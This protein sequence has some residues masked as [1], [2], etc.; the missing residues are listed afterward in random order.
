MEKT[1]GN[2]ADE[3]LVSLCEKHGVA[4]AVVRELLQIEKEYQT[5]ARRHGVYARIAE[6]IRKGTPS[7]RA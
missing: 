6:C 7:A 1:S 2:Q 5:R 4:P 3:L